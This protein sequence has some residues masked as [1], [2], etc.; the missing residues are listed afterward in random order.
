MHT[1]KSWVTTINGVRTKP[2]EK[3]S[4]FINPNAFTVQNPSISSHTYHKPDCKTSPDTG[5]SSSLFIAKHLLRD[6]SVTSPC[7][8]IRVIEAHQK[9][10]QL[11]LLENKLK[12]PFQYTMDHYDEP[13]HNSFQVQALSPTISSARYTDLLSTISSPSRWNWSSIYNDMQPVRLYNPIKHYQRK[14]GTQ[15]LFQQFQRYHSQLQV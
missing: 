1:E 6:T 8:S 13:W 4:L 9:L 2:E 3:D 12:Q 5:C 14:G 11:T 10:K 7:N 15:Q